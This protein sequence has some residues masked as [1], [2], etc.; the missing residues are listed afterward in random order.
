MNMNQVCLEKVLRHLTKLILLT[1]C[2]ETKELCKLVSLITEVSAQL[3]VAKLDV[4]T[5][6]NN[7]EDNYIEDEE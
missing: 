4:D 3:S 1:E 6:T 7:N 2:G 5:D